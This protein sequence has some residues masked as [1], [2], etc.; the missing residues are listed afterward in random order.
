MQ[1]CIGVGFGEHRTKERSKIDFG[2]RTIFVSRPS[3]RNP[4]IT[5]F[6][7]ADEVF[8]ALLGLKNCD[9]IPIDAAAR[10]SVKEQNEIVGTR[11]PHRRGWCAIRCIVSLSGSERRPVSGSRCCA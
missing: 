5:A 2:E 8:T 9:A 11:D 7:P 4:P 6:I 10:E 1:Y 3:M